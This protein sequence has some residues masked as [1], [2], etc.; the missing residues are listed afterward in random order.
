MVVYTY[1]TP[2]KR[3]TQTTNL[4]SSTVLDVLNINILKMEA[5][6]KVIGD[7]LATQYQTQV[8]RTEARA[9]KIQI[10]NIYR[11]FL[12][13]CLSLVVHYN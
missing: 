8:C 7:R 2:V 10:H 1:V 6:M 11:N 12:L 4:T 9:F 5:T 3:Q 13:K